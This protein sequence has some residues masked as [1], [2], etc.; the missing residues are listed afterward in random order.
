MEKIIKQFTIIIA[1]GAMA[2][3]FGCGIEDLIKD[4]REDLKDLCSLLIGGEDP[5]RHA[6]LEFRFLRHRRAFHTY[7]YRYRIHFGEYYGG[8]D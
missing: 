4:L 7:F 6:H 5:S 8:D 2:L 1:G 3:S